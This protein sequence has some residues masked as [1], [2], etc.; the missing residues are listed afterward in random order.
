MA[1]LR[2]MLA[3]AVKWRAQLAVTG[4]G[5]GGG[6]SSSGGWSR[7]FGVCMRFLWLPAAAGA[8]ITPTAG[9]QRQQHQHQHQLISLNPFSVPNILAAQPRLSEP[10][11]PDRALLT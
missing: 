7:G 10:Q 6:G 11:P 2:Q 8:L 9:R 4:G 3:G 5:V 1:A